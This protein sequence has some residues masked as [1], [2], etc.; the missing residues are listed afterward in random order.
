MSACVIGRYGHLSTRVRATSLYAR[1]RPL[2]TPVDW[3]LCA[4]AEHRA[5]HSITLSAR[6]LP[7][8][9]AKSRL[10]GAHVERVQFVV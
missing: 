4:E 10:F 7:C 3:P 6:E 2:L 8:S 1:Q 9:N 5:C